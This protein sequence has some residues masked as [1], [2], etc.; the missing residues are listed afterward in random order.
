MSMLKN[1]KNLTSLVTLKLTDFEARACANMAGVPLVLVTGATG[2][3]ASHIIAALLADGKYRVRG[4]VRALAKQ[5]D[6]DRVQKVLKQTFP[7]L[8]LVEANLTKDEGWKEAVA[9]C[10]YIH[11]V[12]S[13]FPAASPP[14]ADDIIRPAVDGTRRVLS[15]CANAGT[16]KRVVL[17]SSV[18]SISNGMSGNRG[19]G[20]DHVYTSDDWT[21]VDGPCAPYEQ[22]KT[23]AEKAAWKFVQNLEA[24]KA[25]ELVA[26]NPSAV[27][28]PLILPRTST[29]HGM[30]FVLLTRMLSAVPDV[31]VPFVDVRDVARAHLVTMTSATA[32]GNR[33][34]LW[35]NT[36][37]LKEIAEVLGKEFISQGYD[38]PQERM[39]KIQLW[40]SKFVN[41]IAKFFYSV[42]GIRI[43]FDNE[44]L[45]EELG[46]EPIPLQKTAID[47]AY[48]LI[49]SGIIEKKDDYKGPENEKN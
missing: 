4:T 10:T 27:F 26:I 22:S 36:V 41:P 13:P 44:K 35:N 31:A 7:E 11:H 25:F 6:D 19:V 21:D 47:T 29:S 30:V 3:I 38:V 46:I 8:E 24:D 45:K 28:G 42:V 14:N 33:Y 23:I 39:T 37:W 34:I 17:T 2:F 48:S 18:S 15:A 16:V 5:D 40:I 12:A 32:P 1:F 9:G 20:T 43:V 49:E